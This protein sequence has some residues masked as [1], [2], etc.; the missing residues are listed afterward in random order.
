MSEAPDYFSIHLANALC[1][2]LG[3]WLLV[4]G[5]FA[6]LRLRSPALRRFLTAAAVLHGAVAFW[7]IAPLRIVAID[8]A[9]VGHLQ[10]YGWATALDRVVLLG[11]LAIVLFLGSM[12]V[13]RFWR[14][15][16]L[17]RCV[18]VL[19]MPASSRVAGRLAAL[20]ERLG[21]R[22]PRLLALQGFDSPFVLGLRRPLLVF[23]LELA[24]GLTDHEL[25]S[26][27][28]HELSHVRSG[29]LWT[30]VVLEGIRTLHFFNLPLLSLIRKHE[31]AVEVLR[32]E[33]ACR[34]VG[35]RQP[36]RASLCKV[37]GGS[38]AAAQPLCVGAAP[39]LS[40]S[41]RHVIARLECLRER[42][43]GWLAV[44]LQILVLSILVPWPTRWVGD[45]VTVRQVASADPSAID[46]EQHSRLSI[47]LGLASNPIVR[48]LSRWAL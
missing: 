21:T 48:V 9:H 11:W 38:G 4:S 39:L 1:V 36:L 8:L 34:I 3:D 37:I 40:T 6:L 25:D 43:R 33:E 22:P 23:P 13:V 12:R 10:S 19:G 20:C 15:H 35:S 46:P 26:V 17:L 41:P 2:S 28:A 14:L 29:D 32:D 42:R 30:A 47:G 16:R 7:G 45:C 31:L 27:L 24:Q 18:E 44:S 5:L